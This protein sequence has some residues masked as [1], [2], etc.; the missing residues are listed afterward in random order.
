MIILREESPILFVD[1]NTFEIEF[2]E[3]IVKIPKKLLRKIENSK[4]GGAGTYLEN[5]VF[6]SN[7]SGPT[8]GKV[9]KKVRNGLK[10]Q[11]K[12][13]DELLKINELKTIESVENI[14]GKNIRVSIHYW[15]NRYHNK[16]E[17]EAKYYIDMDNLECK[18]DTIYTKYSELF[19]G[20]HKYYISINAIAKNISEEEYKELE[21]MYKMTLKEFKEYLNKF[22]INSI[23]VSYNESENRDFF[24]KEYNLEE[25][26]ILNEV[27]TV[28]EASELWGKTEGT[29]RNAIKNGRF[30]ENREWRKAGRITLITKEGLERVYGKAKLNKDLIVG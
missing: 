10:L 18:E 2:Y 25:V 8:S 13:H 17:I 28:T 15:H 30:I 29:I 23:E 4:N 12:N 21:K 5:G 22:D 26:N 19:R 24:P 20:R 6:W 27:Y 3:E 14:V 11:P 16:L 7:T 1:K 9:F